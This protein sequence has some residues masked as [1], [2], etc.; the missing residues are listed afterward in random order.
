MDILVKY[1]NFPNHFRETILSLLSCFCIILN[2]SQ[3]TLK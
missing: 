3:A 1:D 2:L